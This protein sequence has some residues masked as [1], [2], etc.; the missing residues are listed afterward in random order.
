MQVIEQIL[1][2]KIIAA[3]RHLYG[4]DCT[5]E[6]IQLQKTR[7]EFEGDITL[8]VFPLLKMSRNHPIIQPRILV[9]SCRK[10]VMKLSGLMWSKVF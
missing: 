2:A 8:V 6:Q 4:Q 10:I 1:T 5:T 7:R 9:I 3:I